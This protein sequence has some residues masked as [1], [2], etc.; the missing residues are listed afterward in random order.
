MQYREFTNEDW[1]GFSG[2]EGWR[3]G[4]PLMAWAGE[5]ESDWLV[6]ADRHGLEA[7]Q[8]GTDEMRKLPIELPSQKLAAA[9]LTGL[10]NDFN[11]KDYG[12]S[13]M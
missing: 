8:A 6:I 11:P 12:F 9:I 10:P 5:T 2:A 1:M 3:T 13:R 7:Y 4:E